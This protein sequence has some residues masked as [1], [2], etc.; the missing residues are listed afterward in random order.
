MVYSTGSPMPANPRAA[1]GA[2]NRPL[3]PSVQRHAPA[4]TVGL[5][6]SAPRRPAYLVADGRTSDDQLGIHDD[7]LIEGHARLCAQIQASGAVTGVQLNH[8]GG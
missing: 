6:W 4:S 5:T 8:G 1:T 3:R 7:A 2:G